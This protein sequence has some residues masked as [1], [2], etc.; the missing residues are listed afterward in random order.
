MEDDDAP[1]QI[2]SQN[3]TWREVDGTIIALDLTSSTY[4]TANR[5]GT[6]LWHAM[7]DSVKVPEL[8]ALLQ[9]SF[10]IS[11]ERATADVRAFLQLLDA[12]NLLRR[13]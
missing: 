2:R 12:N 13:G 8:I 4:F 6:F 1:V 7:T 9:S 3:L 5:V 11:E 10:G